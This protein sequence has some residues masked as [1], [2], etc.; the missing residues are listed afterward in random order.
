[1]TP[2]IRVA[3]IT[4]TDVTHRYLLLGQL[5]F[6]RDQG[7]EVT[8]ISAPGPHVAD[9]ERHGIRHI[10]WPHINRAWDPVAD[11]RGMM[12]L[13]GILRRERFD[14][15]HTHNPKPGLIGRVVS[16]FCGVPRVVNTVHGLYAMPE[17]RWIKRAVVLGLEA[18]ASRFS[19]RELYQSAADLE[20]ALRRRV[21]RRSKA[22]LLGNGIDV[23][24]F[25]ARGVSGPRR[26]Q[27]RR[28]L[29]IPVDAVVVGTVGR[30]VAEKGYRELFSAAQRLESDFP[31]LR[32]LVVGSPDGDKADAISDREIDNAP[33]NV[34]FA[35][36]RDDVR[37][38]LGLMDIFVLAS[39]REGLPRS[40]IE[41]AAMAR[42]LI[43]TDIRGCRE[44]A[45]NGI[46]GILIP[47]RDRDALVDAIQSMLRDPSAR[48]AMGRAARDRAIE[49]FDE[50][51][52]FETVGRVY[53]QLFGGRDLSRDDE[54]A[55]VIFR[56]ATAA[57][58]AALA[59]LHRQ[60][61]PEAFL[62]ALGQPFLRRLYRCL[63]NDPDAVAVVAETEGRV[64]GF[65]AGVSSVRAFYR[66]FLARYGV[67]A[68]LVAAPRLLRPSNLR[69]A[70]ETVRYP[71]TDADLPNSELLAIAVAPGCRAK[72][73]GGI[74]ADSLLTQLAALGAV[75][76]KV[77]VAASNEGANRFYD[78]VGFQ[79]LTEITV[80][81]GT[82]S[83]VWIYRCPSSLHSA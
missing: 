42:P 60:A 29:G 66:R 34:A 17:D 68:G 54:D 37:D 44:V 15:V 70:L 76:V 21:V 64:V 69:R 33:D 57:D 31:T 63:A 55:G 50:R 83:N 5:G 81:E 10:P 39:Y 30:L 80:H 23:E 12:A 59:F 13:V 82:R 75:D 14:L 77:V 72:G 43:L 53:D 78:R 18:I 24:N 74:L 51:K 40:A 20:W 4:T 65:A 47:P 49:R 19:D 9:L 26:E 41:A 16:R 67:V 22:A 35:G 56:R 7:Y 11:L 58:A 46:E 71:A 38:L 36:W 73:V 27:L 32:F 48:E 79:P 6:L 62:P 3:H 28:D 8:A 52:V 45:R 1:M 2:P 25:T 61:L